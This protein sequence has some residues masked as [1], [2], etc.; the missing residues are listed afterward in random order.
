VVCNSIVR[1]SARYRACASV[2][3]QQPT[4]HFEAMTDLGDD[5]WEEEYDLHFHQA[6]LLL[7][8]TERFP[9]PLALSLA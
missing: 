1:K 4:K 3:P 2:Q 9:F 6:L 8:S 5:A 7:V